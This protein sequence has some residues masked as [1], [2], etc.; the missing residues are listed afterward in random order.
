MK[1]KWADVVDVLVETGHSSLVF[2]W[3]CTCSGFELASV[4]SDSLFFLASSVGFFFC[5]GFGGSNGG[6]GDEEP[7]CVLLSAPSLTII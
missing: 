7:T 5:P 6:G 4:Y 2:L 3:E 1:M